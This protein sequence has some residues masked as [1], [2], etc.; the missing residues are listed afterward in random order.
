MS[1]PR[2]AA[3]LTEALIPCPESDRTMPGSNAAIEPVALTGAQ[4]AAALLAWAKELAHVPMYQPV[5]SRSGQVVVRKS[6]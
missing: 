5:A 6:A 2:V 3:A 1:R 4:P